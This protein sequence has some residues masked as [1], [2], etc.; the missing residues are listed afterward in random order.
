M[1]MLIGILLILVSM[2][3]AAVSSVTCQFTYLHHL[4]QFWCETWQPFPRKSHPLA[5]R[6]DLMPQQNQ[7]LPQIPA[8][9]D[10]ALLT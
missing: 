5:A 8:D 10:T 7:D 2:L 9:M 4:A 6:L 1:S 3:V